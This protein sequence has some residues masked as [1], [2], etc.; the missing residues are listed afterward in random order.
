LPCDASFQ[1]PFVP[2][3]EERSDD[4]PVSVEFPVDDRQVLWPRRSD[5]APGQRDEPAEAA[6]DDVVRLL[7]RLLDRRDV[8][9]IVAEL[10]MVT[11]YFTPSRLR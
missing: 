5:L 7:D 2:R 4:E 1:E 3:D 11:P 10:Q 9:I 6:P 8:V